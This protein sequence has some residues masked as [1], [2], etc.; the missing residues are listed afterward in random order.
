MAATKGIE[1]CRHGQEVQLFLRPNVRIG[2]KCD[3]S[4]FGRGMI[5]SA[6]EGGLSI[7]ETADLM[8]FSHTTVP[9]ASVL[10]STSCRP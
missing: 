3:L 4:D 9:R 1:A 2:K 10:N 8:G 5:V 7:S 6:R